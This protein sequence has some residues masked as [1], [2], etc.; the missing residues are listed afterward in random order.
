MA[1]SQ[2]GSARGRYLTVRT[3]SRTALTAATAAVLVVGGAG[4]AQSR[5][6]RSHGA[7][8]RVVAGAAS[9]PTSPSSAV[10]PPGSVARSDTSSSHRKVAV[11]PGAVVAVVD[12]AAPGAS[13]TSRSASAS[14]LGG[15]SSTTST[16]PATAAPASSAPVSTTPPT[17]PNRVAIGPPKLPSIDLASP[18]VRVCA[19]QLCLNGAR[20]GLYGASSLG[21]LGD[22]VGRIALARQA[23]LN[24]I[25]I[26][27]FLDET[28]THVALASY[29]PVKW[30]RVDREIALARAAGL[31]VI[32]DLSTYRNLLANNH[33]NPYTAEWGPFVSFVAARVNT[34]TGVRYSNDPTIAIVSVAGEVEPLT[35]RSAITPTTLQ[36][37]TFYRRT[38]AE[39]HF[40]D[41]NHLV[42]SGGLLQLDW[43]SGIDWK[44]IFAL[45]GNNVPAIHVYSSGDEHTSL[46]AV[47]AYAR[48]IGKP[49]IVEEFGFRQTAGDAARAVD[50]KRVFDEAASR[51]AAGV[52]FWNVG[53]EIVGAAGKTQT[54]DVNPSTPRTFSV[55]VANASRW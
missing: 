13:P 40:H 47:A 50:F 4:V 2:S 41:V 30:A 36:L 18:F 23:H 21:G 45:P 26:V 54:Y 16:A 46:P 24:V 12:R 14:A 32:L 53:P 8:V 19:L 22:P 11:S 33:I 28:S 43:K 44:S 55:V 1:L 52:L 10:A 9:R 20:F 25:R 51:S 15:S 6:T 17:V 7:T 39:L 48:L 49:W 38:I 37:T 34:F 3:L 5:D 42:S 35:V 27:N 29:D 31:H